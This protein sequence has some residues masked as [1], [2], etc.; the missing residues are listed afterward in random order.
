MIYRQQL[1]QTH[2]Q[3]DGRFPSTQSFAMG[4]CL[5]EKWKGGYIHGVGKMEDHFLMPQKIYITP[6]D[7]DDGLRN[8][9]LTHDSPLI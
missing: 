3:K 8:R 6:L 7:D 1:L 9:K 5:L 4:K 2:E